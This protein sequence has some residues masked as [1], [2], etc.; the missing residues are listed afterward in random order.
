MIK[1]DLKLT[2]QQRRQL[3]E[4]LNRARGNIQYDKR[5]T[6]FTLTPLDKYK[7]KLEI[8][9]EEVID[10]FLIIT[11][12]LN[13]KALPYE[14][15]LRIKYLNTEDVELLEED[16]IKY[17]NKKVTGLLMDKFDTRINIV[18]L[19]CVRNLLETTDGNILNH[20]MGIPFD[21]RLSQQSFIYAKTIHDDTYC[22]NEKEIINLFFGPKTAVIQINKSDGSMVLL[23]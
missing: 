21:G 7:I 14:Y 12:K 19:P 13:N 6:A 1:D 23:K 10:S 18:E 20:T 22:D 17:I 8:S 4:Q 2:K 9:T 3:E 16:K 15:D 11:T 5:L